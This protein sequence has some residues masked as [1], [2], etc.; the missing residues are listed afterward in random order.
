MNRQYKLAS[1]TFEFRMP[2]ETKDEITR[3]RIPHPWCFD[4]DL[5]SQQSSIA[6]PKTSMQLSINKTQPDF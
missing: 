6:M 2:D 4:L 1:C 5:V 3:K